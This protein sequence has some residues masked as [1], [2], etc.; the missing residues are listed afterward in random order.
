MGS[1]EWPPQSQWGYNSKTLP[2]HRWIIAEECPQ[3]PVRPGRPGRPGRPIGANN[4]M[5]VWR[6]FRLTCQSLRGHGHGLK[7]FTRRW[8]LMIQ[9]SIDFPIK[10]WQLHNLIFKKC[11]RCQSVWSTQTYSFQPIR[12]TCCPGVS[13]TAP[14]GCNT[15]IC[16]A[17]GLMSDWVS[18]RI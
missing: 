12:G 5:Y 16:P 11:A 17:S 2:F 8:C 15:C 13:Y 6:S 9:I 1:L 14:D 3:P 10:W 4:L 7:F 18:G